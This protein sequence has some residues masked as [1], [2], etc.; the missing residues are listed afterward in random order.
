MA[1]GVGP[2]VRR[3]F[4][5]RFDIA[6]RGNDL[7][8]FART[9]GRIRD[10]SIIRLL[11]DLAISRIGLAS[12][13]PFLMHGG[14]G[15]LVRDRTALQ[16]G[17]SNS[18]AS[19]AAA[20]GRDVRDGRRPQGIRQQ[21]IT[22][23]GRLSARDA[24]IDLEARFHV[25]S[26]LYQK[27]V[28]RRAVATSLAAGTSLVRTAVTTPATV[29]TLAAVVEAAVVVIVFQ[30]QQRRRGGGG[31]RLALFRSSGGGGGSSSMRSFS[32]GSTSWSGGG[33]SSSQSMRS[34][35]ARQA[36]RTTRPGPAAAAAPAKIPGGNSAVS[37]E[38][39]SLVVVRPVRRPTQGG[40]TAHFAQSGDGP[41]S[42]NFS[43]G[44][45]RR[46]RGG[47]DQLQQMFKQYHDQ[48]AAAGSGG[49]SGVKKID[50]S[51]GR[52]WLGNNGPGSNDQGVEQTA[53]DESPGG[54]NNGVACAIGIAPPAA[55]ISNL[56][57]TATT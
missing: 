56:A 48:Q 54:G 8:I 16:A 28:V 27:L 21:Q 34:S 33:S 39:I 14:L 26:I 1:C 38:T 3:S 5:C 32:R 20:E 37:P 51:H 13:L 12:A 19:S 44:G 10:I 42:G 7:R 15:L 57:T 35:A 18:L 22:F 43:G 52:N 53:F 11:R 45:M 9:V 47:N 49:G 23:S 29:A 46:W 4:G 31:R 40:N 30:P 24:P 6:S 25:G 36:I 2:F 41:S 55:T 17:Q 50:R